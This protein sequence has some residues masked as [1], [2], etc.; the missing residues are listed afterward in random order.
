[1]GETEVVLILSLAPMI[2]ILLGLGIY[3]LNETHR[4]DMT[5]EGNDIKIRYALL[6]SYTPGINIICLLWVFLLMKAKNLFPKFR[7]PDP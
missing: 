1:M 2:L 6:L 7:N 5:D 4:S 3:K